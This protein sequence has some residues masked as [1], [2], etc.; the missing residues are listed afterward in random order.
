M[1][2]TTPPSNPAVPNKNKLNELAMKKKCNPPEYEYSVKLT[3][4]DQ[5][6]QEGF[7][8]TA[9]EAEEAASGQALLHFQSLSE[10]R[11]VRIPPK[12]ES[13]N[14]YK[15][16]L[17][18]RM[19]FENQSVP[20]YEVETS[21]QVHM[22]HFVATVKLSN[23]HVFTGEQANTKKLSEQNAAKLACHSLFPDE[24]PKKEQ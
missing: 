17:H 24:L 4:Q 5:C 6:F 18:F 23:G 15:Q 10:D 8:R 2:Q 19:A 14:T 20:V 12:M 13:S 11:N 9:R 1:E 7:Y 22:P 3:F 21:G 16:Y